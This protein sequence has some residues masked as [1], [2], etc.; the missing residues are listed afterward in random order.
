MLHARR[1]LLPDGLVRTE[2]AEGASI[3]AKIFADENP[4]VK[5]L[6]DESARLAQKLAYE[7]AYTEKYERQQ[8]LKRL[9]LQKEADWEQQRLDALSE[10]ASSIGGRR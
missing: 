4:V 1:G 9:R 10:Q 2:M 7:K 6:Q 5:A 3:D 8:E